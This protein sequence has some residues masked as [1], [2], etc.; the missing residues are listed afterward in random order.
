[1][2]TILVCVLGYLWHGLEIG[3]MRVGEPIIG[4]SKKFWGVAAFIFISRWEKK[5]QSLRF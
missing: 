2:P 5:N 4:E 3:L 1:M